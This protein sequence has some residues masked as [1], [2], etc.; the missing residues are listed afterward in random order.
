MGRRHLTAFATL[1]DRYR[2]VGA[3]DVEPTATDSLCVPKLGSEGEAI[4][5]ADVVVIATPTDAHMGCALRAVS[6]GRNVLVE[7]PLCGRWVDADE[8]AKLSLCGPGKLFVGHS[9]RF[10]PVVRV[11]S[12]L[13]RDD[14]LITLDLTRVG[15]GRPR[16]AGALLNMG[17]HDFDLAAYLT[18]TDIRI[19]SAV[20]RT[21]PGAAVEELAH[22]LFVTEAGALGHIYV[23]RTRAVRERKAT[24]VTANW[25]YEGDLLDHRLRR[26]RCS[27]KRRRSPTPSMVAVAAI[28]LPQPTGRGPSHGRNEPPRSASRPGISEWG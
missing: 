28:W 5:C 12:R 23:D 26:R 6:A 19:V 7:K 22:V 11:L 25:V 2:I 24:A 3:F 16:D 17:V 10:N 20:T 4:A 21:S 27:R 8:V 14:P 18:G 1:E 9:E 15:P 13:L